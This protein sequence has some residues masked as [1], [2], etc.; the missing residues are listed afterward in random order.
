MIDYTL[1]EQLL[2][3][4][5]RCV[6]GDT[7]RSTRAPSKDPR[8]VRWTILKEGEN[9][10]DVVELEDQT[11]GHS[12]R[13]DSLSSVPT[14][15]PVS[16]HAPTNAYPSPVSRTSEMAHFIE[17]VFALHVPLICYPIYVLKTV[18]DVF[19][20]TI[21]NYECLDLDRYRNRRQQ[22]SG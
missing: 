5:L 19:R 22:S 3:H 21:G 15:S 11:V 8:V 17:S 1:L 20:L 9:V 10:R 2:V 18:P 4:A 14:T 7:Q 16:L 12:S 13:F 6:S